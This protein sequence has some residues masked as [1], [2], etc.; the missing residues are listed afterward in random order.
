M[1]QK[2]QDY[3]MDICTVYEEGYAH[4]EQAMAS[5]FNPHTSGTDMYYAWLYGHTN[6]LTSQM[7]QD[8][9]ITFKLD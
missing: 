1:P 4:A 7:L 5:S 2:V 3:I 9:E 6:A 8:D